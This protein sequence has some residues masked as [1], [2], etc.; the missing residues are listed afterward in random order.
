MI[1]SVKVTEPT[2][3]SFLGISETFS[4]FT[5]AAATSILAETPFSSSSSPSHRVPSATGP[6]F[7]GGRS[8]AESLK[9]GLGVGMWVSL[10]VGVGGLMVWL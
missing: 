5:P 3:D 9:I 8:G 10:V 4:G 7:S 1:R 6:G 2:T